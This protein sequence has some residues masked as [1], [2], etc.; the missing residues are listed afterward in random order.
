MP[1]RMHKIGLDANRPI[2][3][4]TGAFA[5]T[6]RDAAAIADSGAA[7]VR[8]NFV[9]G[10]WSG[11]G[12]ETRFQGRTWFETYRTII[13]QFRDKGLSIYGLVGHEAVRAAP[14]FFQ[15]PKAAMSPHQIGQA[16][17][18]IEQYA[19]NFSQIVTLFRGR[20]NVFESF[21]EPDG[22]VNGRNWIEPGWFAE[23]LQAV[24][25][26]IKVELGL[27]DVTLVSG[28]L[29]G[30]EDHRGGNPPAHAK[31]LR[32]TYQYGKQFL[33]WGQPNRPFPFDG[34]GYHLY[35][36]DHTI[37]EGYSEFV[38][39]MLKE[40]KLAEGSNLNRK[41]YVS[42]IGWT[43]NDDSPQ[44]REAQANNLTTGLKLIAED[45][46]VA[47]GIWFC[48]EDFS[49]P[50]GDHRQFYGL[51]LKGQISEAGRK[52]AFRAFKDICDGLQV[53]TQFRVAAPALNL[54]TKPVVNAST[55][56][57]TLPQG[58]LVT[59]LGE[60]NKPDWW[61]VSTV[62]QENQLIGVVNHNFLV[63]AS[64]H[65]PPA[66]ASAGPPVTPAEPMAPA[67]LEGVTIPEIHMP[68]NN[69]HGRRNSEQGRAHPL[70]EPGQPRRFGPTP[71]A[72][73]A[74][75][76]RIIEWLAVEQ[77]PRYRPGQGKTFCN[78]YAYD[79][80][81]LANVYL[82][83]VWWKG[84]AIKTLATGG[85]VLPEYGVTLSEMNANMIFDWLVD[86]GPQFGWVRTFDLTDL[87][88][89]ANQGWVGIICAQRK[90]L[91]QPGHICAA[92]P[93]IASQAA[94]WSGG[95][96]DSPL[97]SQAGASNFRYGA[98]KWW[99]QSIF[100]EFG[101]WKHA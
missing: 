67:P 46:A 25:H 64:E 72:N 77:S 11:P 30:L 41:L 96:V 31:Y 39:G 55:R 86:F 50:P 8:L 29:Q 54:R 99:T 89:A 63:P 53:G 60:T 34:L 28:P 3:P 1:A 20:V 71:E 2:Q 66:P 43:S 48:T 45:P 47:V 5:A 38:Q 12:D 26:K 76:T 101:F 88:I 21:N 40:I 75:L 14:N 73:A 51:Y 9:L 98:Q 84:Q 92:V 81:Y 100:R 22:W 83:R 85:A 4:D 57:A 6:V 18:W 80:C 35:I 69:P 10:P 27:Q 7:W 52:P 32:D 42:E 90:E 59:R 23:M 62:F 19:S 56:I 70:N 94:I 68:K 65:Q 61:T 17:G 13:D 82:P 24:Y 87:Q 95:K 93:E 37:P 15:D 44:A 74:D 33:G 16:Q 58:H 49:I 79:Y 97:Q 36:R 78:I 91:N